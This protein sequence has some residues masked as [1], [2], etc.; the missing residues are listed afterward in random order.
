M[1]NA[2]SDDQ[3]GYLFYYPG[4]KKSVYVFNEETRAD[5][6]INMSTPSEYSG[7]TAH[8]FLVAISTDG[9]II[10]NSAYT[11]CQAI[12]QAVVQLFY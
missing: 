1:G 4:R 3:I 2:K 8:V 9:K 11:K 7:E 5:G 12:G 6:Y 10:S